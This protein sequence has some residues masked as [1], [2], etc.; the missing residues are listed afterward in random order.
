[1]LNK[2]VTFTAADV[3]N[4][5]VKG[6]YTY[7]G[8]EYRG[9]IGKTKWTQK[10]PGIPFSNHLAKSFQVKIDKVNLNYNTVSLVLL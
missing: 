5:A 3:D 10:Y 9:S 6:Y 1:M 7:N 8:K 4:K 2:Q